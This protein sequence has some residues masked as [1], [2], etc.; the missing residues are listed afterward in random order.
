MSEVSVQL[1]GPVAFVAVEWCTFGGSRKEHMAQQ[2]AHLL[3]KKQK[4]EEGAKAALSPS[5]LC[6]QWAETSNQDP[7]FPQSTSL[8]TKP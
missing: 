3:V 4:E 1:V 7:L 5:R 2:T 8:R 6:P